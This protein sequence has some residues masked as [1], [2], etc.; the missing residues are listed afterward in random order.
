MIIVVGGPTASGKSA[1]ALA[2]AEKLT[3]AEIVGADSRQLYAGVPIASAGPSAA[4]RARVPHHL[5]GSVDPATST[6]TAASFLTAAD[7]AIDDIVG[8]G[9]TAIVVGGTGLYLRTLRTGLDDDLPR[10][11]AVKAGLEADLAKHGLKALVER[12]RERD[13]DAADAV[14]VKNPVR[15]L[16]ALEIALLGG[17]A[18]GR[19]MELLLARP[20]RARLGEVRFFAVERDDLADRIERRARAMFMGSDVVDEAAALAKALPPDHPLLETIGVKEAL[21]VWQ[22]KSLVDVAI[23]RTA[24][25]TRQYARRQR[26]WFRKE[27]WWTRLPVLSGDGAH[28]P[29]PSVA[30]HVDAIARELVGASGAAR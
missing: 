14:D 17:D 20:P 6:L 15:V 10:D 8:R 28:S 22:G 4:G 2:L 23:T 1:V 27:P 18:G 13:A 29:D 21:E 19:S 5:Y 12:L 9:K 11:P 24:A 25:R 26:T 16:R 7:A 30:Q 3:G